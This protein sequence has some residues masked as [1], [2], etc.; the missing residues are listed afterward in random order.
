ML[1][2]LNR[3]Q[4]LK[5][6]GAL[7]AATVVGAPLRASAAELELVE[8][9]VLTV[10]FNGDM[11]GTGE[12]D[13]KLIGLDGEIMQWVGEQLGLKVKPVLME[14]AAEI[15]S[16]KGRRVDAMHG[17]MGWNEPRT[18]VINI[19]DPIYYG[20]ATIAQ[21]KSSNLAS[22]ADLN[23]KKIATI[24]GFGWI[25]QLKAIPG[26]ELSLYDTSDAAMRDL[27]AGRIDGLFADPPLTQYVIA[28][29]P[30]WELHAVPFEGEYDPKYSLLT[31]KYNVVFGLSKDAP[32]LLAAFNAKIAEA[33][34]SCL[35]IKTAAKYG[36]G[37]ASWFDPGPVNE[38]AGKDRPADWKPPVLSDTC[39]A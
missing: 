9:G 35:N 16:V 30:D 19:T 1:D 23:G 24:Q 25:D 17:M 21:K 36:L 32:N 10:A 2:G 39:K 7:A 31:S 11:P 26:S 8:P 29:N 13:G 33:W 6:T 15:E 22:L 34:A 14:W 38:R 28:Q 3:R 18:K 5:T 27:L 20:G 37:D 12:K 4:F